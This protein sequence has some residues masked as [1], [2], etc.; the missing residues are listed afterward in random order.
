M[1]LLGCWGHLLSSFSCAIDGVGAFG[2]GKIATPMH[3]CAGRNG[4]RA[5][6]RCHEQKMH[7][8]QGKSQGAVVQNHPFPLPSLPLAFPHL[9]NSSSSSSSQ[10]E[11]SRTKLK[12]QAEI[13]HSKSNKKIFIRPS[14]AI[15]WMVCR[16]AWSPVILYSLVDA[17]VCVHHWEERF[18]LLLLLLLLV[19][20]SQPFS[21]DGTC[22]RTTIGK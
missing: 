15:P 8:L 16:V 19:C 22:N 21:A 11:A 10:C 13:F 18:F 17:S 9:Q 1:F 4:S 12:R 6:S 7:D 14:F 3:E 20:A 2:L 5:R